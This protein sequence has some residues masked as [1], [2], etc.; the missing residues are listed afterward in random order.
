MNE[1]TT[2][3]HPTSRRVWWVALLMGVL[4]SVSCTVLDGLKSDYSYERPQQM[5][6]GWRTAS[7]EEV[8]MDT[9]QM[10]RFMN[11]LAE[12]PDH[13]VHGVV[14]VKDGALVFEEYFPGRDLDLSDL[15]SGMAF[16]EREFDRETLH[17]AA[18]VS[19]SVTSI[20]LGIAI[21]EGLVAGT[22]ETLFS[23]FP[24][25][26]HLNDDVKGQI[27]LEQSLM[28]ASGIPWTEGYDYNDPRNDLGA[29][30]ASDDPIGYVLDKALVAEPGAQF[31]YNSGTANLLGEVVR[32]SS[33][34]TLA[35]YAESRLFAPLGIE[36]YEWFPFPNESDMTVA[37]STLYLRPRD[38]AKIGQL[39]LDGGVW[40]GTRLVSEAWLSRSTQESITMDGPSSPVPPLN[41]AYGYLWWLGTFPTGETETLFAAG[42]GGQFIFILPEADMVVVFTAGGFADK[43]YDGLIQI[44]NDYI[45]PA[46]G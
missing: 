3:L 30:V 20:L 33:G 37:S 26:A 13:W 1:K 44:V 38:M 4:V 39:V 42:Y 40:D 15:G 21:D 36:S 22:Q 35:Q 10:V 14:V 24:E 29:M 32:R 28:M 11:D 19:K 16:A 46:A 18:S 43:N 41:P 31:I 25:Y 27:T 23:Y 34:M 17:S 7:L 9:A 8:G 6:D 12:Y 2:F 45:L 5:A